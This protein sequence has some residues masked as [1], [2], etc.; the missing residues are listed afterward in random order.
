MKAVCLTGPGQAEIRH[1][2]M[3]EIGDEEVLVKVSFV[4]LCGSDLNTYRGSNPMVTYPRV[5]GHEISGVI[6]KTGRAVPDDWC[7][8]D[9]V[10]LSPYTHCGTCSACR[11]ERYNCCRNNQT[12]GVQRDG[13]LTEYIR[14][15]CQKL[16]TSE[17][18]NLRHLALVE[19]LT[20]GGHAVDRGQVTQRDRVCVLGCGTIGLGAVAGAAFRGAHV[21]AVDIDDDKLSLATHAG[22]ALTVNSSRGDLND[23]LMDLTD[24]E[25][26]DV[27]IEAIGLPL[28]FRAAVE[29][30]AF[31]GRVVYIGYAK[32]PVEYDSKLFVQKELDIRG[33]RN[34]AQR[35]F[36]AAIDMLEQ[37]LFPVE[38]IISR[39]VAL[40][41]T[42]D[43]LR[44]WQENP[45][46]ITKILVRVNEATA[47]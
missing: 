14:V 11:Q 23:R 30:V 45:G 19:P 38:T 28:T 5:P 33:S 24:G 7:D 16:F 26:V 40:E 10:T 18:L 22:A 12:F 42:P 41:E 15:P 21:I 1:M 34:A 32:Q 29:V 6:E 35:D 17:T 39:T 20:V 31:A 8:G 13:A 44:E 4:G 37:G 43:A 3:P 27:V 25:G 47:T 36:R 9:P 46:R 2:P